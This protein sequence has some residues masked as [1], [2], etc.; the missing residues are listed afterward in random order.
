MSDPSSI[1]NQ[2]FYNKKGLSNLR[3]YKGYS[4]HLYG[5]LH[6][7]LG[8]TPKF[9]GIGEPDKFRIFNAAET[10]ETAKDNICSSHVLGL[11]LDVRRS[12]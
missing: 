10:A 6:Q 11:Q 1:L 7:L 8:M 2:R 5:V 4:F 9:E 3:Q 12:L